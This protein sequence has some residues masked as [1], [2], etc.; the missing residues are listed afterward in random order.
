MFGLLRSTL[1]VALSA[2]ALHVASAAQMEGQQYADRITLGG[3]ALQLNGLGMRAVAWIKG[4]VAGLYV[5][6]KSH[7]PQ[8]LLATPGAKRI[9]LRMLRS[10]STQVFVDALH[11]GLEKNHSPEQM[12]QF[13]GR[14]SAFD[15]AIRAI[16]AVKPGDAV[17]LD[18][19]PG[20]GLVMSLNGQRRGQA[21]PGEDFY[22]GV[23]KIFI[24]DNPVDKRMKQG[25]LGNPA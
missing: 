20:Q 2:A 23:M 24:G 11:A 4:Y 21:I 18:Y 15:D 8:A 16:G 1:L 25:L 22:R 5:S 13:A 9:A 17:N 19:L 10:A 14:M 7:D 6:E 12:Q 3:D